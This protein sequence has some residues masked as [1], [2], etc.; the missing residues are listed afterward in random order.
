MIWL[1]CRQFRPQAI[2]AAAAL[3]ALAITFAM[4]G[5][6][7]AHLYATSGIPTCAAHGTCETLRTTFLKQV[8]ADPTYVGLYFL[9]LAVLYLTPAI[10]GMFWGGPLLTR[11]L[12]AGTLIL[13]FNQSVTRTR[14][15]AIKLG[16]IGLATAALAGLLSLIITW[17]ASPIDRADALPGIGPALPNRFVPLIFG[18]RDIAPIGYAIFAF[19]LGVTAGVLIRRTLPAMALTLVAVA[20]I[21]I[22][23]PTMVRPQLIP[24]AHTITAFDPQ[25]IQRIVI[26]GDT[27]MTVSGPVNFP[28][29]WII[30]NQTI[31]PTGRPFTGPPPPAC[32]T[33]TDSEQPCYAALN[34]LHLRQRVTYQ[35]A[36]RYWTFQLYETAIFLA[37][38]AALAALSTLRIR[39]LRLS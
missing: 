10:I 19:T 17:W 28:G 37:L 9:G 5:P 15:T 34:Q 13:T 38:A 27:Y 16:L 11:E 2:V 31:T 12:E 35:P 29:A 14:W 3:V 36:N 30:T 21:Q 32:L 20:A 8:T 24:A 6:N 25:A 7:L 22:L 39:S 26:Q 4:T 18:A 23:M 1:T 33:P